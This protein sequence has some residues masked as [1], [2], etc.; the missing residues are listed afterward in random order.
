MLLRNTVSLEFLK[1]FKENRNEKENYLVIPDHEDKTTKKQRRLCVVLF[2]ILMLPRNTVSFDFLKISQGKLNKKENYLV[3][4]GHKDKNNKKATASAR[5][6]VCYTYAP[7]KHCFSRIPEDS[8][9]LLQQE[10]KII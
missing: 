8:Q 10:R 4:P 6:S 3:T 7:A 2:S 5:C 1:V 9:S